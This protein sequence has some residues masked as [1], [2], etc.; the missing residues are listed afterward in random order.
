MSNLRALLPLFL[1]PGLWLVLANTI[2]ATPETTNKA[3]AFVAGHDKRIKPLEVATAEA[4]WVANV[5]GKDEDFTKKVAAQNRLDKALAD[6]K[7]FAELKGLK[8]KRADIDD[9]VLA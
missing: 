4:W 5:S 2:I 1:L 9:P 3:K 6:P 8:N 7:V